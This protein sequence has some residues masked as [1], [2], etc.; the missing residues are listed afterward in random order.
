MAGVDG[1]G[2][3]AAGAQ[4][5]DADG[6]AGVRGS[7]PKP[8]GG[9]PVAG[10]LLVLCQHA[11]HAERGAHSGLHP[12]TAVRRQAESLLLKQTPVSRRIGEKIKLESRERRQRPPCLLDGLDA[13]SSDD[14]SWCFRVP[15]KFSR[16]QSSKT[17]ENC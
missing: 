6:P 17:P 12:P 7:R 9:Q 10:L 3:P 1:D 5:S 8:A 11:G 2:S 13:F 15:V 16:A 4:S 14:P